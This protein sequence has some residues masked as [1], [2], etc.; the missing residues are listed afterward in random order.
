MAQGK[1]LDI[2]Q[3][4]PVEQFTTRVTAADSWNAVAGADVIVIADEGSSSREHS[5]EA[6]LAVLR[7][8]AKIAGQAPI[9]FAGASQREL[10]ARTSVELKVPRKRLIGSAPFALESAVRAIAAVLLDGSG[11]EVSL[12]VIGVPPQAAVVTWEHASAAS[13]PLNSQL[14][15][16][17]I[18][19]VNARLRSLWPPGPYALA[20]AAARVVEGLLG[21]SRRRFSCFVAIERGPVR[22]AV[23]AMP[24]ELG[25]EGTR[26]IIEPSLTRQEQTL[27]ENAFEM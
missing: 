6:G 10:M 15:A 19:A 26:R 21:R 22:D 20:S 17:Q 4:S 12:R 11:V 24:V 14:G 18:A 5:G 27:L 9:V 7:Q 8:I 1:A 2:M 3:S 13:L 25:P 23:V 16:H